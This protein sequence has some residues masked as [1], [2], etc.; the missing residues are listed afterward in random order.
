MLTDIFWKKT[1]EGSYLF[2]VFVNS[3]T[4]SVQFLFKKLFQYALKTQ[5]ENKIS[6]QSSIFYNPN[7]FRN[8]TLIFQLYWLLSRDDWNHTVL[9]NSSIYPPVFKINAA[10]FAHQKYWASFAIGSSITITLCSNRSL[11]EVFIFWRNNKK[12]GR[13]LWWIQREVQ[14]V[15]TLKTPFKRW[16]YCFSS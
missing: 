11:G 1:S 12:G 2:S 9:L 15:T 4:Y 16:N 14:K 5:K 3:A 6:V 7:E 8:Q 10:L 13:P